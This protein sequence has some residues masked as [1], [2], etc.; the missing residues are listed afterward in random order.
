MT[1]K[2]G[3]TMTKDDPTTPAQARRLCALIEDC[4]EIIR[5]AA[6][7][8][9]SGFDDHHLDHED[10]PLRWH[11]EYEVDGLLDTLESMVDAGDI[12]IDRA[13]GE[14][15]TSTN[16]RPFPAGARK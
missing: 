7:I 9:G 14:K 2:Q 12:K 10:Q 8:L 16:H 3:D 5:V 4:D 11:L 1:D 15:L 6:K 13:W